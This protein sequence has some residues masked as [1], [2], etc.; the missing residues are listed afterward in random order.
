MDATGWYLYGV[1]RSGTAP[2]AAHGEPIDAVPSLTAVAEGDLAALASP[3][4]LVEFGE[5]ELRRS[6]ADMEWV[7]RVARHHEQVLDGIS[8]EATVIPMRMCTVYRS[9]DGIREML[10]REA[11]VLEAT[12][13]H[14]AGRREWGV[15]VF[16]TATR[17]SGEPAQLSAG[18]SGTDYLRRRRDERDRRERAAEEV[19]DACATIHE[20]LC[21]Q[22]VEGLVNAPQRR[23]VSGHDG[24]MVLNGVYL[25]DDG[26][27]P[28]FEREVE[29]LAGQYAPDGFELAMTGPWPAYNFLPTEIGVAV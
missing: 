10:A 24:E 21:A 25:V 17:Q 1:I 23:E 15:K 18:A 12:L 3:V 6:L 7:E 22:S 29:L 4:P 28:A 5:A 8:A 27:L 14:L 11:R 26:T 20:R 9:E 13:R 16:L 19:S 2:A